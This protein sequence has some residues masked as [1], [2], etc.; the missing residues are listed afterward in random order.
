MRPLAIL[1]ALLMV[2]PTFQG[3]AEAKV[4]T[5]SYLG[6]VEKWT[7]DARSTL[8]AT[9]GEIPASLSARVTTI[10][11]DTRTGAAEGRLIGA[12]A[13]IPEAYFLI[14]DARLERAAANGSEYRK[15]LLAFADSER[16]VYES[17]ETTV[18]SRV[19]DLWRTVRTTPGLEAAT[20]AAWL[21]AGALD[22]AGAFE[23]ARETI[24]NAQ[25]LPVQTDVDALLSASHGAALTAAFAADALDSAVSADSSGA[26]LETTAKAKFEKAIG[27]AIG[28]AS[29]S[30][31]NGGRYVG[32]A[33]TSFGDGDTLTALAW[34]MIYYRTNENDGI[35][36]QL[37][38]GF[39]D[40]ESTKTEL[41]NLV[42][43]EKGLQAARDAGVSG[44]F[45]TDALATA[46]YWLAV[47]RPPNLALVDSLAGVRTSSRL[48]DLY[49]TAS[50]QSFLNAVSPESATIV[51]ALAVVATAGVVLLRKP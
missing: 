17:R 25:G 30:G 3:E 11:D 9:R 15:M 14:D 21:N 40:A 29:I 41:A 28:N 16:A 19:L 18:S 47:E 33:Y 39:R 35:Q 31:P 26:S 44:V 43:E 8:N 10:L 32:K 27:A 48:S 51:V 2:F 6:L 36:F 34:Y 42:A 7:L 46:K 38:N 20:Y 5:T 23:K 45:Q 12:V 1:V 37:R 24:A 49:V 4:E 13:S 22:R 50:P